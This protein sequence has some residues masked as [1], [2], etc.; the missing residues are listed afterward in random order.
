M[1]SPAA[2]RLTQVEIPIEQRWSTRVVLQPIAAPSVLGL[3]GL[4]VA[5]MT[6]GTL[7]AKWWGTQADLRAVSVL[8]FTFGGIAQ[9]AAAMWC[10]RARDVAGTLTHGAWGSYWIAFFVLELSNPAGKSFGH[11]L[12]M[13]GLAAVTLTAALAREATHELMALMR[14]VLTAGAACTAA[15]YLS[16][17]F[18]SGWCTAGGWLFVVSAALGWLAMAYMLL[19]A[20]RVDA[21]QLP[22][23]EPGVRRGQ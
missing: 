20:L 17:G 11:G 3:A 9:L 19:H 16:S 6:A 14:A 5:L 13:V 22:W 4:S 23:A 7:Q 18:G 8:G 10:Y 12:W 21:V 2:R 15:G 1:S